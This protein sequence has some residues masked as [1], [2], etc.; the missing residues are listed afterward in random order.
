[1]PL[2]GAL[3]E[4]LAKLR[5]RLFKALLDGHKSLSFVG[6]NYTNQPTTH[7]S[8]LFTPKDFR[9][10]DALS[11]QRSCLLLALS[12]FCHFRIEPIIKGGSGMN[13]K[14]DLR[15]VGIGLI[16]GLMGSVVANWFLV[17]APVFAQKAPQHEKVLQAEQD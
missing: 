15:L 1:M 5:L 12:A 17:G 8:K 7:N 11:R 10:P 13:T 16:A 2:A 3:L 4:A 9:N 6:N 14:Q